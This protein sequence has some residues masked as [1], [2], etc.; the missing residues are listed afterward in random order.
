MKE[1]HPKLAETKK[2]AAI[3]AACEKRGITV[4]QFAD[5]RAKAERPFYTDD[6]TRSGEPVPVEVQ[7]S[8]KVA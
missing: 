4:E 8:V 5:I 2:Q 7:A 1:V 6:E 3:A